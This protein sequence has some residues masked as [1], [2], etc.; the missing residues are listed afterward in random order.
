MMP[1][2]TG[3]S[4]DSLRPSKQGVCQAFLTNLKPNDKGMF[5]KSREKMHLINQ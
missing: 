1:S 4:C 2:C 5:V 3:K